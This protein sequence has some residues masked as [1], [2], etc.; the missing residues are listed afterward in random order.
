MKSYLINIKVNDIVIRNIRWRHVCGKQIFYDGFILQD[1]ITDVDNLDGTYSLLYLE[2]KYLNAYTDFWG[3]KPLFYSIELGSITITSDP[4][5]F[6]LKNYRLIPRNTKVVVDLKDLRISFYKKSP[7]RV[8]ANSTKSTFIKS[9][10]RIVEKIDSNNLGLCLSEG[11]DSGVIASILLKTNKP[12]Y[13]ATIDIGTNT[14]ILHKRHEQIKTGCIIT[15]KLIDDHKIYKKYYPKIDELIL[16]DSYE[17]DHTQA[18]GFKGSCMLLE[19]LNKH[20]ISTCL[21]CA[22]ADAL[23]LPNIE[24]YMEYTVT[25]DLPYPYNEAL[26][27]QHSCVKGEFIAKMFGINIIYIFLIKEMWEIS[28]GIIQQNNLS[29]KHFFAEI[30]NDNL[31]PFTLQTSITTKV[32]LE[33]CR[34]NSFL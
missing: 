15:P 25:K 16:N 34:L 9:V 33:R 5:K 26:D 24:K 10:H 21:H 23:F 18:W 30:M 13:A 4:F 2:K 6:N 20:K 29:Y 7:L 1:T 11:Y 12:F 8:R 32:G 19:S 17:S 27:I 22:G 31:F 14:Q 28:L 3:T